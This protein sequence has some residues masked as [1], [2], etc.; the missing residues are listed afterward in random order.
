MIYRLVLGNITNKKTMMT[1]T[2]NTTE[3]T[4]SLTESITHK[5]HLY[6]LSDVPTV[7][8]ENG[9]YEVMQKDEFDK[10]YPVFRCPISNT[11]MRIDK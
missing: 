8:I 1:L 7:R 3:K 4:V 6:F 5:T 10:S 2:F 11:N 9:Y